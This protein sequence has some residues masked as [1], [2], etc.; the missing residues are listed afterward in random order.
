MDTTVQ[1]WWLSWTS[2]AF[3]HL[4]T[5]FSAPWMNFPKGQ[6]FGVNGSMLAVGVLLLPIT[7]LF[8][9]VTAWNIG[10][11]IAI[12]A[13]ATAMCLVLRRWTTWWP[14]AFVGG[15]LYGFS[16]YSQW[17]QYYMFLLFV[18]LPPLI[19][20]FLH[21]LFVRQRWRSWVTGAMLGG[22]LSL[23]F[24]VST[25]ILASTVVMSAIAV[26]G[27]AIVR[28]R[29]LLRR[30]RYSVHA[31][32]WGLGTTSILLAYP[33]W[34]TFAGPQHINGTPAPTWLLTLL[35]ADLAAS[36]VPNGQW[37]DTHSINTWMVARP[38]LLYSGEMY[39]GI[40]LITSLV[41]FAV[42]LR[43]RR[44]ILYAGAMALISFVLSLGG[45]LYVDGRATIVRLPF[46]LFLHVPLLRGF[47][48]TRF[49]LYTNLFAAIMFA[50]GLDE[51]RRRL[52]AAGR[53]DRLRE[54]LGHVAIGALVLVVGLSLAP[55]HTPLSQP[56]NTP[57]FFTTSAIDDV[58]PN[59]VVLA[60]P[61]PD[62]QSDVG[63][64]FADLIP[65][66]SI[67]LYQSIAAMHFKIVGGY[68]WFPTPL[69]HDGTTHPAALPPISVQTLFDVAFSRK[70][71][72]A[73]LAL[74]SSS[75]LTKD[76]RQFLRRYHVSTVIVLPGFGTPAAVIGHMTT[77]IGVPIRQGGVVVWLHVQ[78]RLS[79]SSG[80][81]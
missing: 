39:L 37:L 28:G 41:A 20:L 31:L 10:L 69:G 24:F 18:P 9:V 59:S 3:P 14:A 38:T 78:H 27:L 1:I 67:M 79:T 58:P 57:A 32:A 15:L 40:P 11:R 72:P 76:L 54:R 51:M 47:L 74:L 13:S 66:R 43:R 25:E 23:Q 46:W 81:T 35:P 7:K 65:G 44:A 45:T 56:T 17:D 71:T 42:F 6:N 8:G 33:L 48:P 34:F 73:Q 63:G 53:T 52:E 30:W 2:V 21:E 62:R 19:L 36:V 4:P 16:A 55:A 50:V 75:N 12:V 26:G 70:A 22:T 68:G 77:A 61:Y 29:G 80:P 5:L 64:L 60:F 49:S